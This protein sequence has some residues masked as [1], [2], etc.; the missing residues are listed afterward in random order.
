MAPMDSVHRI[1]QLSREECLGLLSTV[2]I[3]RV[4]F[5][6]RA[7]PAVLPVTF[8]V[9]EGS[10]VI[11]TARGTRLARA[12]QDAVLAFEADQVSAAARDGW[13]VVVTG[14]AQF[15]TNMAAVERLDRLLRAWVPGL[16]DAFIRIPLHVVTGRRITGVPVRQ[17]PIAASRAPA[18][19]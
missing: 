3:G 18:V 17:E 6:D 9:D 16:K 4:V 19:A 15:E 12:A 5:T 14:E 1:E 8:I 10:I 2:D 13:S 7:L 11:R